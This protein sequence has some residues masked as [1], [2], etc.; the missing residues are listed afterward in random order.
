MSRYSQL[1]PVYFGSGEVNNTGTIAKELGMTNVLV[2]TEKTIVETG[3]P[4]KVIDSLLKSGINVS[5]YD[6][7]KMDAPDTT[8]IEGAKLA[9]STGADGIIGCG[10]GSSLDTAKGIA[11]Y[12]TN[13]KTVDIK[14]MIHFDPANPVT[15]NPALKTIMV[16]TTSGTGS[17]S[18]FVAVITDTDTH[19]KCGCIVWANAAIVDPDLTVGLGKTITAY[20]GMDAFSHCNECLCNV[21]PNPHSDTLALNSM[22]RIYK[23]LPVAVENPDCKEARYNLAIASNF[24]GI[25]FQDSQVNVGHAMAHALGARLHVP[26]GIGC[27]LVT[28]S[29]IE[30]VAGAR[31]EIYRKVAEIFELEISSDEEL[32]TKLADAVRSFNRRIGIPSMK[33]LGITRE[34]VLS[35]VNYAL[36]EMMRM[37]CIVPQD[38]AIIT[39]MMAKVYDTYQ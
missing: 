11:L 29:V 6:G 8:V 5:V 27:A 9:E 36:S 35:T 34:Q 28:P 25:A 2:V 22:E 18:T 39:D 1:C 30:L 26:H 12:F 24:A 32:P 17:E 16:P 7:V 31:P 4:Q 14:K 15:L 23:W 10:G 20:T 13:K 21:M 33:D 3:I 37:G 19:Q 38:E